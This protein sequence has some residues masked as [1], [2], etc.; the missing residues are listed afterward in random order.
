MTELTELTNKVHMASNRSG[1]HLNP[2]ETK[3]MKMFAN[4]ECYDDQNL[5]IGGEEIE[6]VI[7]FYYIGAIFTD[8]YDDTKEIKRRT[9][10]AKSAVVSL[11]KVLK[12][13]SISIKTKMR[14]LKCLVFPIATYGAECWV[15]KDSDLK[16]IKAFELRAYRRLLRVKWVEMRTNEWVVGKL[17][18]AMSTTRYR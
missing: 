1:F 14:V 9:V 16:R 15:M 18:K 7:N 5:V 8:S 17:A 2:R 11:A 10:I 4:K 13:N 12:N 6:T 3:A